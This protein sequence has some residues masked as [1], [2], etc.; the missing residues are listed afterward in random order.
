MSVRNLNRIAKQGRIAQSRLDA[1]FELLREQRNQCASLMAMRVTREL[2]DFWSKRV[3]ELNRKF[4]KTMRNMHP[5]QAGK[6][7]R[8]L[9]VKVS[10]GTGGFEP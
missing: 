3:T 4:K 7:Y 6:A 1:Q 9:I 2:M 10:I 8:D 5:K